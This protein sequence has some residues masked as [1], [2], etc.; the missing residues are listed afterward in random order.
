MIRLKLMFGGVAILALGLA[1][2][3]RS[4]PPVVAAPTT[5]EFDETWRDAAAP[6][7]LKSASLFDTAPKSV[8]TEHID[9]PSIVPPVVVPAP[10]IAAAPIEIDRPRRA[11][12]YAERNVCTRHH[13]HKV[14]TRGGRSWRCRR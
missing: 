8:A 13:M 9:V 3:T 6:V 14:Y 12:R 1:V 2:T 4:P 11:P 5:N 10:V 7:A